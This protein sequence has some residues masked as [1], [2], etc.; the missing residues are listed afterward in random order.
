MLLPGGLCM[1]V[2]MHSI[3]PRFAEGGLGQG[4]YAGVAPTWWA[5]AGGVPPLVILV[6]IH[7]KFITPYFPFYRYPFDNS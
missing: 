6:L 1:T 7:H 4:S 2:V 3:S 5:G